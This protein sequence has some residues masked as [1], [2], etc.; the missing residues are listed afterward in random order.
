MI[1]LD[2]DIISI[3]VLPEKG[4]IISSLRYLG[5]EI[6]YCNIENI[7]SSERPKCGI[8]IL[9]PCCGRTN[10]NK[11]IFDRKEYKMPIHGFAHLLSWKV[12]EKKLHNIITLKL[13]SSEETK[14]YYPYDFVAHISYELTENSLKIKFTVKNTGNNSMPFA[15][16]Y[17]PYF[18]MEKMEDVAVFID[19][20]DFIDYNTGAK[21]C[22]AQPITFNGDNEITY[23][24]ERP[25]VPIVIQNKKLGKKI[26]M[27]S[28]EYFSN[29]ILWKGESSKFVCVEPWGAMPNAL[30]N[31]ECRYLLSEESFESF[32]SFEI[33]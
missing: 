15:L 18:K 1:K 17:H 31:R 13:S 21:I 29:I 8:P 6:L 20:C 33:A 7:L 10:E 11:V 19:G 28:D 16:G 3:E 30:N 32:I 9:F 25:N 27:K 23:I 14:K 2:N 4:G 26:I 12:V 24:Y 22:Y 5:S